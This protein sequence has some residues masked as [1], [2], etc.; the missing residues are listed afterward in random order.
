[1][2][3]KNGHLSRGCKNHYMGP[4]GQNIHRSFWSTFRMKYPLYPSVFW[5]IGI[6]LKESGLSFRGHI[7]SHEDGI[8]AIKGTDRQTRP[9]GKWKMMCIWAHYAICMCRWAQNW[10]H[11]F[12][13]S[14][15]ITHWCGFISG[16]DLNYYFLGRWQIVTY[17]KN[18]FLQKLGGFR[19]SVFESYENRPIRHVKSIPWIL[20]WLLW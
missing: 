10:Y 20:G 7:N 13:P 3:T 15:S 12:E 11:R 5:S 16:Y 6:T 9:F 19:F 1:M 17:V 14:V 18:N 8:L 4:R 2:L